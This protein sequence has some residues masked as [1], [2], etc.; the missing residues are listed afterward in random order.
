[1][2]WNPVDTQFH[3]GR[4]PVGVINVG[5]IAEA[6]LLR[7]ILEQLRGVVHFYLPGTPRDFVKIISRSE[8]FPPYIVICCHADE[9]GIRFG[10][11]IDEIDTSM[12]RKGS[13]P[14]EVIAKHIN[15][16][17]CTVINT[18]CSCGEQPV[19]HAFLSGG[20]SAYIGAV[21]PDPEAFNVPFFLMHFF[22][23]LFVDDASVFEAWRLAASSTDGSRQYVLFDENGRHKLD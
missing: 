8:T 7:G 21:E 16:P 17:G 18:G 10:D 9:N 11:Y 2:M 20:L 22:R 13:M 3:Y 5:D 6:S 19:A 1:M 14:A 4:H 15:L 12:L 23:S